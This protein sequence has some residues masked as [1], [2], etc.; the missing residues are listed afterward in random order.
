M[1][2]GG[3]DVDRLGRRL[4]LVE[5]QPLRKRS[6]VD[7][8]ELFVTTP[9]I[10]TCRSPL[11]DIAVARLQVETLTHLRPL[12]RH[13]SNRPNIC[14]FETLVRFASNPRPGSLMQGIQ[15]VYPDTLGDGRKTGNPI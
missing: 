7:E 5:L 8:V 14:P 3:R 2:N 10:F 11:L 1:S 9:D 6:H 4:T 13:R 12:V 15:G